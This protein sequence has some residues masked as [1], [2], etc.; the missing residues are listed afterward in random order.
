MRPGHSPSKRIFLWAMLL[1]L[2]AHLAACDPEEEF[3]G[4]RTD[5]D[6][7]PC[8]ICVVSACATDYTQLN[9]CGFCGPEPE[10]ICGTGLDDNCSGITDEG[11]EG[12]LCGN[13]VID[14]GETCDGDCPTECHD[15]GLLCTEVV[16]EGDASI[17]TA[18]CVSHPI[19]ECIDGDGCCPP[20]CTPETDSD[21]S[22]TCGDGIV[23][24]GEVCDGDCPTECDDGNPCTRGI[25]VGCPDNCSAQCLF[26]EIRTCWFGDGCCPPGCN[27]NNDDDC[28]PT[29]GDGVL[30]PGELCDGD[31]PTDCD[32]G[33]PC[34][35]NYRIGSPD[36]CSAQC[37]KNVITYCR[38]DDG[39]CPPGCNANTDSDCEPVCGNGVIEPGE[40]C[41][42]DCPTDC[43]DGDPCTIGTMT[44]SP[45]TCDVVCHFEPVTACID[46][47]GCCP[48]GCLAELDNDCDECERGQYP[49]ESG[50]CTWRQTTLDDG[51][52]GRFLAMKP[53]DD[54]TLHLAYTLVGDPGG[55]GIGYASSGPQGDT[56]ETV[57]DDTDA[58]FPALALAPG[59]APHLA[60][61]TRPQTALM[62]ASRNAPTWA[63][64]TVTTGETRGA[65][66]SLIFGAD[67]NP[68]I[69]H[70]DHEAF[71]LQLRRLDGEIWRSEAI[72]S[73]QARYGKL[74]AHPE[75]GAAIVFADGP[76]GRAN[77]LV[78]ARQTHDGG[79]L[80]EPV[81]NWGAGENIEVVALDLAFCHE[82]N[83]HVAA[84]FMKDFR[85]HVL[86]AWKGQVWVR[87]E[88]LKSFEGGQGHSVSF[89][90]DDGGRAHLAYFG[91]SGDAY[92]KGLLYLRWA[93]SRWTLQTI[94]H[95][96]TDQPASVALT[97]REGRHPQFALADPTTNQI[98][99]FR[100]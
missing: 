51:A 23:D 39:C 43:D 40:T 21:C 76:V 29:C 7:G 68:L 14:W 3:E 92:Y 83:P 81:I 32:D 22:P 96:M 56:A 90:L 49:C 42:G 30:D 84:V 95:S 26:V 53:G 63:V 13:G 60:F 46:D 87:S 58:A 93:G 59:G 62:F 74:A 11:C 78:Y 1:A 65:Y 8:E 67:G 25:L 17:C 97:L 48:T 37:L 34:T 36:N 10:E 16:L 86:H 24:P 19:T 9:A 98:L 94:H 35:F 20:G 5:D 55:G 75:R 47:D 50:C 6:C 2:P 45:E 61:Q 41:D 69:T 91:D 31:C 80:R 82:G 71:E 89:A 28:S 85:A 18:K 99:L 88:P 33:D 73:G 52:D 15:D 54:G 57:Y 100:H 77:G 70:Y 72:S 79:W 44:G 27:P 64:E 66:A 38:D 12:V 4:C